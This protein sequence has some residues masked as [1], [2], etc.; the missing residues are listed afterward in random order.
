MSTDHRPEEGSEDMR[1]PQSRV[2]L[3]AEIERLREMWCEVDEQRF[4]A[5]RR[6]E[7]AERKVARARDEL[8]GWQGDRNDQAVAIDYA[9]AI[10]TEEPTTGGSL[11]CPG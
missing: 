11:E 3:Q 10:L 2:E 1:G 5:E 8:I 4:H 9:L 6:A 7:A